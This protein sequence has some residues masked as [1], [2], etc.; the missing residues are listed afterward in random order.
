V[1]DT[2]TDGNIAV[3][4]AAFSGLALPEALQAVTAAGI[5]TVDLPTDS[6]IG[7]VDLDAYTRSG[8]YRWEL[9]DL[10]SHSGVRIGCVSNSRDC[11]LILG[12]HGRQTDAIVAG[13]PERKRAH[14]LH[15]AAETIRLATALGA[16]SVR[17][18][19][20]C[21][22][23]S[24][25]LDWWGSATSWAENIEAWVAAAEPM[26]CRAQVSGLDVLVEPHPKQVVYDRITVSELLA[27]CAG[28]PVA[29]K[30]CI[31]PANIAAV[32]HDPVDAVRGWGD[33]LAAV[34][35][36]DLQRWTGHGQPSGAGW[37]RYG[38]QPHI[39]FR[40]LG[41][42]ELP[43]PAIVAQLLD[44]GFG[45]TLYI[46]HE[47]TLIPR[48]QGISQA[49]DRLRTLLPAYAPEGRTW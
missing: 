39:R 14:G 42:G 18:M 17:L 41:N 31:D 30:L 48:R 45:G 22:D 28:L 29:P 6:T 1:S 21:P 46:E 44:E 49:A 16:S 15:A 13:T 20:G 2:L 23:H 38:P 34:H 47:D 10:I 7:F 36:K 32:G 9:V 19:L 37:S 43:W 24:L 12:P 40:A 27:A 26:L 11:Q 5:S 25:W 4:L 8:T 35:V 3:C 33:D